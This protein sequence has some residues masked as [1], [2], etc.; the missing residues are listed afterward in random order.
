MSWHWAETCSLS[1]NN[2]YFFP[3]SLIGFFLI[4][5][6][7]DSSVYETLKSSLPILVIFTMK[8]PMAR[9]PRLLINLSTSSV[10]DLGKTE[11]FSSLTGIRAKLQARNCLWAGLQKRGPRNSRS[12]LMLCKQG[13][14][15]FGNYL[16]ISKSN[17][18]MGKTNKHS[19]V[20]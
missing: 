15:H 4:W 20:E 19:L 12:L 18:V 13:S 6:C 11:N 10:L 9:Y 14:R 17:T 8:L 5:Q 1:H 7:L 16:Y 2:Y 3:S